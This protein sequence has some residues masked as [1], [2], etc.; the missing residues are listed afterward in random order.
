MEVEKTYFVTHLI[1]SFQLPVRARHLK[2]QSRPPW[3]NDEIVKARRERRS[4]E[5]KWRASRLNSDLAVFKAKR[6][7]HC[8][9]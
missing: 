9:S 7:L 8:M 4:A 5:R 2:S 1:T 6:N 3:L